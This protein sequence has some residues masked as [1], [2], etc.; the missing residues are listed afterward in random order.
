VRLRAAFLV[1]D[2]EAGVFDDG[3]AGGASFFGGGGVGD[4]LLEPENFGA[5]GDGGIGD[6]R[7]VL[8]AAEDI[9]DVDGFGDVFE[10]RVGFGAEDFGFVGID[11]NNF[12]ADGLEVGGDSVGGAKGIAGETDD[13]DGF[14]GA[15][16]FGDGVRSRGSSVGAVEVHSELDE[17]CTYEVTG[18]RGK[19]SR[20]Q[21]SEGGAR[22]IAG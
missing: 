16:N 18:A 17:F 19:D 11:G 2:G 5:D 3:E 4:V 20:Y 13:G 1:F 12:I 21:R 6:G 7:D 15:E 22:I 8:G 9:D 10:T 14:G